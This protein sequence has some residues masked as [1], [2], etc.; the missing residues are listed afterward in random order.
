MAPKRRAEVRATLVS[1][2][3]LRGFTLCH[4]PMSPSLFLVYFSM[5]SITLHPRTLLNQHHQ[6]NLYAKMLT[7]GAH[8]D[9]SLGC[10][11]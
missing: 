10:K 1:A 11:V 4:T 3:T 8:R 9:S 7:G 2:D 6:M 5:A